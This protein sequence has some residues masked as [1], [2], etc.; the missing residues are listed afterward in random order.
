MEAILNK[1][2]YNEIIDVLEKHCKTYL[3]KNMC[4]S[5]KPSFSFELVD[6]LLNETKEADTLLHQKGSPPFYETD[7][8]EKYI[9]ILK[10]NQ[11]LSIKG[12]LNIG[13]LLRIARELKEYFYDNN[14]SSFINLEKYFTLLYS[15]PSIEKSIF[16]KIID[17]STIADNASKKLSS[18]RRNRK[19]FEQEVKDKLN[20]YIHSSTY[21]KYIMEPIVT[22]RNNRYVIPVKEEYRSYIKGFV[23]D[24]SSSGS[25]L[26]I[27][28]TSIFD[29]NNKINHIKIEEDLEIEKIL[30]QLSASLY[31]YTTELD[32]DL[33]LIANID[34]IFA[35]A[36]FGIEINGITPIL[37][38]EKFVDLHKARHPLIDKDKVVPINIGLGKD[39]V[40]LLITGPNTGG[41]TVALKTLGL[42]LLMAYS[43]IPIPCSE[44]SNICVFTY[45]FADIGDEQSIQESLSTFSAHMKNIV[46][47][48][49]KANDNS[50]V[51]LDELGSGTDPV[52][53]AALAISILSYLKSINALVCCTT[54]YQELKEFALVTDGFENASFEFDI[55]NLKP[56]YKLL[57][58]IPGKS[59]AFAISKKLGL[60]EQ[61]LN[62]ANAH[63]KEDKVSIEELLKNIYDNKL[64]VEK[65]V[66]ETEKNLRQV[67]ALR[68]SL[69]K[70]QDDVL[71]KRAKMLEDAKL[72][73][74]DILLSAKEEATEII[75]EL[76]ASVDLK[77]ANN[78]RNK[79]N[80][81][82]RN[83]NSVHYSGQDNSFES[84]DKNDIKD[85]LNVY[86]S[87]LGTNG[88]IL[89]NTVN[90]S[91]EVQVQ[92]GS[93]KMN[94]KLSDFRKLS[95]NVS[96]TS[97]STGKVTTEKSSKTK[98]I[99]PEINVI[100][101][102]VDE[103]IYVI[104]KYL[105]NCASANISPVRIV[106][107]KGTGKLREGI[108]SFLKKHPHVKSFRIGTFG[109][110]EM[111]VTVVEIK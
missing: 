43:G 29:L 72:E 18:L 83:I 61:I 81:K 28:P 85:G 93:M 16:D 109:E 50:L 37:N 5:L 76:S 20:S 105:D 90:K 24:T 58:G 55:E 60:D 67:E 71:E 92:V 54:H 110:G 14:T 106:H 91:N 62:V 45:I 46:E 75:H 9:K 96:T 56:T 39:Y 44:G 23:H 80:D 89:G 57:V 48:T 3:G 51:L 94:V 103:A 36:H 42:L 35:K 102:N 97:K 65:Q 38:N 10:S 40:S 7:E 101:Q 34:L 84:I 107:G 15:N 32:N 78:L 21:A 26:Y 49:K 31:A 30:H 2:E 87:S 70:K 11:T 74:R 99:S 68:K 25:T 1:L 73:A 8:L 17:E 79:L 98:V 33:N 19:N 88:I 4:D 22:I 100:G 6:V 86:I 27:E 66:E 64:K 95:S 12:L 47:I 69:E 77:Q 82:I 52:E 59:N 111:G 104:D 13:M 63:L 108:H 41:K 53:G